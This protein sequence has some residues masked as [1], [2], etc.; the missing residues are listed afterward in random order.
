MSNGN[1]KNQIKKIKEIY[2]PDVYYYPSSCKKHWV[3]TMEPLHKKADKYP[4]IF[5]NTAILVPASLIQSNGS[6]FRLAKDFLIWWLLNFGNVPKYK[7]TAKYFSIDAWDDY[8]S[9]Y[10]A[11]FNTITHGSF[12]DLI[13]SLQTYKQ[14]ARVHKSSYFK[15]KYIKEF[16]S[17]IE[18]LEPHLKN[19]TWEYTHHFSFENSRKTDSR[20]RKP[21]GSVTLIRMDTNRSIFTVKIGPKM[22]TSTTSPKQ[23]IN[24]EDINIDFR[25]EEGKVNYKQFN[26]VILTVRAET[27]FSVWSPNSTFS[28]DVGRAFQVDYQFDRHKSFNHSVRFTASLRK[29]FLLEVE[30][31]QHEKGDNWSKIAQKR[32]KLQESKDEE[33]ENWAGLCDNPRPVVARDI[34]PQDEIQVG[35]SDDSNN[36]I[37]HDSRSEIDDSIGHNRCGDQD[38]LVTDNINMSISHSEM[39]D[40]M[41]PECFIDYSS[42]ELSEDMSLSKNSVNFEQIE[43][44]ISLVVEY[45]KPCNPVKIKELFRSLLLPKETEDWDDIFETI[46]KSVKRKR[47]WSNGTENVIDEEEKVTSSRRGKTEETPDQEM[48][49]SINK[50]PEIEETSQTKFDKLKDL[51]L[52]FEESM[53]L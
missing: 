20:V 34:L 14:E 33:F 44:T 50:I 6:K 5:R 52:A 35:L 26:R 17:E 9:Y 32:R 39:Y 41:T 51:N 19:I 36:P 22:S 47:K 29:R 30:A 10:F 23:I 15:A 4:L 2:D 27:L 48:S 18:I 40:S 11:V 46:N 31:A 42:D 7:Y 45:L 21:D 16:Y 3:N 43:A 8:F 12:E 13:T 53:H 1:L 25:T 37:L 24:A 38:M 28:K 49:C